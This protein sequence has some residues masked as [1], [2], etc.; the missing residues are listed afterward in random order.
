[1]AGHI[2]PEHFRPVP[3]D[4]ATD[5]LQ[6]PSLQLTVV[7]LVSPSVQLGPL[8]I[9]PGYMQAPPA[10]QPVAPQVPPV[11]Q[12]ALQHRVRQA[13]EPHSLSP[14]QISPAARRVHTPPE[15]LGVGDTHR[16]VL[17][18]EVQVPAASQVFSTNASPAPLQTLG[19][20]VEPAG[21]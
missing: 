17:V 16:V 14:V 13:P 20:Q 15:H 3:H 6:A 2:P 8:Q 18:V 5:S 11:V 12:A 7:T 10:S 19:G 1:V 4:I 9:E 21:W